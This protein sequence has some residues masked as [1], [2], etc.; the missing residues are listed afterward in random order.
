MDFALSEDQRQVGET[1]ARFCAER[2]KPR[3]AALDEARQFPRELFMELA[4]LG[5]FGLR[6]PESLGGVQ[7]DFLSY[8]LALT[9][10]ARGSLSLAAAAAMQSLMGTH[11]LHEFGDEAI[12]DRLLRPAIR[13]EKIGTI[14]ITEP[15]AGSDLSAI[16]TR[17]TEV[18]G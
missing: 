1:F 13:G 10:L 16:A 15:D 18:E 2:V 7:L 17:A 11:F 5:F 4:D 12:H 8:C 9:E 14:C 6:Y 3:A